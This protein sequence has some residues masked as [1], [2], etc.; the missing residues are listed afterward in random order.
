MPQA[1]EYVSVPVA[2][3]VLGCT[4]AWVLRL[5]REGALEGFK[6]NGRAWAVK[7]TSLEKNLKEYLT[8]DPSRAGRK[9]SRIG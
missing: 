6:L 3:E 2:S 5:L 1:P 8:R 4:D 7:R 9:R